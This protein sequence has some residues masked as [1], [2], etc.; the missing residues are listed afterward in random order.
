M[1]YTMPSSEGMEKE[2]DRMACSTCWANAC[3]AV[4]KVSYSAN[5]SYIVIWSEN[6]ADPA[7]V[8]KGEGE[9]DGLDDGNGGNDKLGGGGAIFDLLAQR[10]LLPTN[11]TY[12]RQDHRNYHDGVV[13]LG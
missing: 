13:S 9:I 8:G 4:D 2:K 12:A 1:P 6:N 11:Y 5:I 3:P 10:H 7:S